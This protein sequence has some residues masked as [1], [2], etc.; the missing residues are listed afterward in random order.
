MKRYRYH[1]Y[2]VEVPPDLSQDKEE[3]ADIAINQA[4]ERAR[5]Y[6]TPCSWWATHDDGNTVRVCRISNKPIINPASPSAIAYERCCDPGQ[7]MSE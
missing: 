2:D 1:Y 7:L 5:L 6:I 3:R 4:R